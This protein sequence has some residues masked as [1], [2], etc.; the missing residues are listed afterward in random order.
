MRGTPLLSKAHGSSALRLHVPLRFNATATEAT[1]EDVGMSFVG[2]QPAILFEDEGVEQG[3]VALARPSGRAELH[4]LGGQLLL[5]DGAD[6]RWHC[7]AGAPVTWSSPQPDLRGVDFRLPEG[8][9]GSVLLRFGGEDGEALVSLGV[10]AGAKA[11]TVGGA[12]QLLV[13]SVDLRKT[14]QACEAH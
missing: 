9:T 12:Q 4:V 6:A 7:G 10:D 11:L 2:T 1:A 5:S 14:W 13:D 3:S 8:S